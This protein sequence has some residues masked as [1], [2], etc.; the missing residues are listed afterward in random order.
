[1][2]T[3][4]ASEKAVDASAG[5]RVGRALGLIERHDDELAAFVTVDRAGAVAAAAALDR[6]PEG[7][8]GP[9]HGLPFSVKD[10][11]EVARLPATAGSLLLRDHVPARS[12]TI[13]ERLRDA[14]A[15]L[16]GKANCAEFGIGNLENR[17]PV[18]GQTR[19][20]WDL[21]R[22]PGGSSGGDATAVASG[23]AAFGVGT[24]FGGSVRFPAHFTGVAALRPSP[25]RLPDDGVIPHRGGPGGES[26]A[27]PVQRELQTPGF[28]APTVALL[29]TLLRLFSAEAPARAET[30]TVCAWFVDEVSPA[31]ARTMRAAADLF[32]AAGLAVRHYPGFP[33]Q[34]AANLLA[35]LRADEGLPELEALAAG[36]EDLLSPA[37]VRALRM[38]RIPA[39][40]GLHAEVARLRARVAAFMAD[41]PLL[42]LPV[43]ATPAFP[44]ERGLPDRTALDVC[45]R[46]TTL[47]RLPSVVVPV[48]LS[49]EGLPI[50]VQVAAREGHDEDALAAA[51]LLEDARGPW[52]LP[53]LDP[54]RRPA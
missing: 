34:E 18:R 21:S 37:V 41:H 19:N 14:G 11:I 26:S 17:S 4:A 1:V 32:A 22:S 28:L 36:R 53:L 38:P 25:G 23:M 48:G 39:R 2:N 46:A 54:D 8:R 30:P 35:E 15:V 3:A 6:L 51:R 13:V 42:L 31:V 7:E 24:D 33:A 49:S 43:A 44:I 52:I 29:E 47:L 50:G 9:L 12:A 5:E 45:T 20:P 27:S 10:T 16:V 40:P